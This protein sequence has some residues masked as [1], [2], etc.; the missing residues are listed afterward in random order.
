[1]KI[2][3]DTQTLAEEV[4][5][6]A[7]ITSEKG[8]IPVLGNILL[9]ADAE[10]VMASTDLQVGLITRCAA[11]IEQAG[12]LTLPAKKLLEVLDQLP[13]GEVTLSETA[14]AVRLASGSFR[15]RLQAIPADEFPMLPEPGGAPVALPAL[16]FR[17]MLDRT[18]YAV[19][20]RGGT[21]Y[22]LKGSLL[23]V[24]GEAIALVATDGKRL[25]IATAAC[26]PA[27]PI[28]VII[29][30][31]TL[32]LLVGHAEGRELIFRTDGKHL[33]FEAGPRLLYSQM[34]E[35][36]FPSYERIIPRDTT[37]RIEIGRAALEAAIRRV[38][39]VAEED[40]AIA[41][42]IAEN[43]CHIAAQSRTLG[44]AQEVV[45]AVYAGEEIAFM[46]NSRFVL[47]F[48]E[49]AERDSI[50]I[51]TRPGAPLLFTDGPDFVNVI[52]GM[53]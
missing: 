13:A 42:R 22:A 7:R 16:P 11:K 29:P 10:L 26:P 30:S 25:S 33:F 35:A 48:L 12:Q 14:G 17:A 5:R 44:D 40:R 49:H 2:T 28:S 51:D 32:E 8:A 20:D 23:S 41:F 3:V 9:R 36:T 34:L 52:M 24:F 18:T 45:P 19:S 21:A 53:R 39:I 27:E 47:D 46:L 38:G 43:A 4:R 37:I 15:L 6:L 1:M 50:T 31:K